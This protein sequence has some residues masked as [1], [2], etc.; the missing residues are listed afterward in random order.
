MGELGA[1]VLGWAAGWWLLWRLPVP[2]DAPGAG[3]RPAMSVI[4]PARDEQRSLPSA[5]ASLVGEL[6]PDDELIVVDDHSSDDTATTARA[7]GATVVAAPDPPPGWLGKTWACHLGTTVASNELLVFLDADTRAEPGALDR[8]AAGQRASGG[9]YSVQPWHEVPRPHERLA[10]LFNVVALMGTGAFT[11]LA[12]RS[13]SVGAFGPCLVTTAGDYRSVGGH[14]SVRA[15]VLDDLALAERYRRGGLPVVLAGG[16]GTIRFRMYPDGIRQVVEGFS[17]NFGAA[18]ASV[19][20]LTGVLVTAWI[21][22]LSTPFALLA[23]RPALAGLCYVAVVAQLAVQ[24]RRIGGFGAAT[25]AAY[26]LA[27]GLFLAVFV[28]SLWLTFVRGE[29]RWKGRTVSTRRREA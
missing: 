11:P 8:L 21:T 26:G 23:G 14:A 5:L 25:A 29:V 16:R 28:R 4:I 10:A 27:L 7:R 19:R 2:P 6:R 1:F 3:L 15:E 17:K 20:P 18:A 22:A 24:L 12:A 9:L 13:R